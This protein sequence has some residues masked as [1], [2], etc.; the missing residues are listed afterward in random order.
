MGVKDA[1]QMGV[2]AERNRILAL[3]EMIAAASTAGAENVVAMI[4]AAKQTGA[5][6]D[7]MSRNMFRAMTPRHIGVPKS[8]KEAAYEKTIAEYNKQREGTN[9]A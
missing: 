7:V 4:A 3:D 9:N 2:Q 1:Y 6:V 5:S 8:F